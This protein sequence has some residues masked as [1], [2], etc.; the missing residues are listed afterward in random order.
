MLSARRVRN[1]S[2]PSSVPQRYLTLLFQV[3]FSDFGIGP[4]RWGKEGQ[5]TTHDEGGSGDQRI[6]HGNNVAPLLDKG[7]EEYSSG[8]AYWFKVGT[9]MLMDILDN[10][11]D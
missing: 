1:A 6:D 8:R 11:V 3:F 7:M 2:K 10:T 9:N 5:V 4:V